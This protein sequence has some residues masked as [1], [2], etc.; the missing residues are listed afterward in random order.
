MAKI[1]Y[2]DR[3]GKTAL[4]RMG[5]AAVIFDEPH[6]KVLL[7]RRTDNNQWCLPGGAMDAGESIT[8][9]CVREV[10]EETG[11]Q[12]EIVRLIGIY[13]TPHRIVTYPDGNRWQVV[14]AC[15][16]AKVLSGSLKLNSEVSEFGYFSLAEIETL[17]MLE[18]HRERISDAYAGKGEPVVA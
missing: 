17:D 8:E 2:G 3:I 10:W 6:E 12:V 16:E 7:T 1:L 18:S 14:A 5:S 11:L 13:S 4:L 15:F 9:C